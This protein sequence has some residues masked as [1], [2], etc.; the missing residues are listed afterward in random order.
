MQISASLGVGVD[1]AEYK[2]HKFVAFATK[3]IWRLIYYFSLI[4]VVK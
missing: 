2:E 4:F 3:L 1:S